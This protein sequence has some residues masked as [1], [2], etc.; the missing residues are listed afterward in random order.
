MCAGIENSET[1]VV[2]IT[3]RYRQK[4]AS[5][6]TDNCKLEFSHAM[7]LLK[8][9]KMIP[10]VM[11][12]RMADTSKWVGRLGMALGDILYVKMW[13]DSDV[14]GAGLRRF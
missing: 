10:V 5:T 1:A 9:G 2:F 6:E 4:V 7:R 8:P 3:E 13:E 11:E 12:K 14:T